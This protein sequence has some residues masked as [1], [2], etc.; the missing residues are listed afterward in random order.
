MEKEAERMKQPEGGED[1]DEMLSSGHDV[2]S[3]LAKEL[4]L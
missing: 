1:R 3:A 2:A 4:S